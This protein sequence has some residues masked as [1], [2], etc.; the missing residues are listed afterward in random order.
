[1]VICLLFLLP[2]SYLFITR[3]LGQLGTFRK[4]SYVISSFTKTMLSSTW[5][6]HLIK[7]RAVPRCCRDCKW[8]GSVYHCSICY[9]SNIQQPWLLQR[10]CIGCTWTSGNE[11]PSLWKLGVVELC[12]GK[13]GGVLAGWKGEWLVSGCLGNVKIFVVQRFA[14]FLVLCIIFW[15]KWMYKT[16]YIHLRDSLAREDGNMLITGAGCNV[17]LFSIGLICLRHLHFPTNMLGTK[18]STTTKRK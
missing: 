7:P 1:M 5:L 10:L 4:E 11:E 2:A 14:H 6:D 18:T 8:Q 15:R 9:S 3:F 13:G 17:S 16:L 12:A